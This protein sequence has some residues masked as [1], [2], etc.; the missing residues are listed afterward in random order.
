MD[1]IDIGDIETRFNIDLSS[2]Q[3]TIDKAIAMFDKMGISAKAAGEKSG[4]DVVQGMDISRGV[5]RLSDQIAKMNET[6]SQGFSKALE[7]TDKATSDR[8]SVV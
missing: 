5:S 2:L 4:K 3:G 7:T 1:G 8:K 6:F